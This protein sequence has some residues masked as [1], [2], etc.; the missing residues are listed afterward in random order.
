MGV[1]FKTVYEQEYNMKESQA[2]KVMVR[3][4]NDSEITQI[5]E[6]ILVGEVE[7]NVED[8]A[9]NFEVEE[10]STPKVFQKCALCNKTCV[11][12]EALNAHRTRLQNADIKGQIDINSDDQSDFNYFCEACEYKT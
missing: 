4:T 11:T 6:E 8:R 10:D 9:Y 12:K 5:K 2:N 7:D 1:I 3:F